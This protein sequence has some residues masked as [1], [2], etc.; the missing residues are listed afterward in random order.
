MPRDGARHGFPL[1]ETLFDVR[2]RRSATGGRASGGLRDCVE[3]RRS[4]VRVDPARCLGDQREGSGAID[5]SERGGVFKKPMPKAREEAGLALGIDERRTR[6]DQS[7][8]ILIMPNHTPDLTKQ[9][10]RSPRVRLG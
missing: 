6:P 2:Q 10:P 7:P 1:A 4:A 9:A 3:L 5:L 8:D